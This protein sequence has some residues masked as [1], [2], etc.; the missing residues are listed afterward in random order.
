MHQIARKLTV[1]L[2]SLLIRLF[3]DCKTDVLFTNVPQQLEEHDGM[4][5]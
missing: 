4:A 1:L 2:G 5:N 3:R